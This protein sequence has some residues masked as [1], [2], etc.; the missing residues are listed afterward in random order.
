[1]GRHAYNRFDD[2]ASRYS[3]LYAGSTRLGCFLE[4][5]ADFRKPPQRVIAGLEEI[6]YAESEP[7]SFGI[8]PAS[9][10]IPRRMG[11]AL[12][13]Q[14]KYADIYSAEWLSHL[15][16]TIEPELIALDLFMQ[17]G[18]FDLSDLM[19]KNR[20]VSQR[21]AACVYEIGDFDGIYYQSRHGRDLDNWALFEPY[22]LFD[23]TCSELRA[24]DADFKQ[25]LALLDLQFDYFS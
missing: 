16:R 3:V 4:T 6:V 10:L 15:R 8:V 20:L 13:A 1:V 7:P 14:R 18:Q 9:W 12:S 22:G 24:A 25:A 17:A 5:L 2:P 21:A 19:T 23:T 11:K